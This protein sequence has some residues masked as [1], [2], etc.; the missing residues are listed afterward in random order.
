MACGETLAPE[1]EKAS[2]AMVAQLLQEQKI[3]CCGNGSS[4]NLASILVQNLTLQYQ[5]ERPGFAA[6]TL[7]TDP[8]LATAALHQQGTSSLFSGQVQAL[9]NPG[10]ILVIFSHGE[11]PGNL[12]RAIQAAHEKNMQ[13]IAFSAR[14]DDDIRASLGDNDCQIYTDHPSA[15]RTIEIHLLCIYALCDLID[16]HLFGGN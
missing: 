6:C 10:D 4:A 9:G 3:L 2:T 14:G 1:L 15:Q 12:I 8:G 16:Y 13:V 5:M 11:D 7:A